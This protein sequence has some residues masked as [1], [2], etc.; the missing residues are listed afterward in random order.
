MQEK[1]HKAEQK[2]TREIGSNQI[3]NK[4][5]TIKSCGIGT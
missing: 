1:I 2:M 4:A 3:Y 5:F